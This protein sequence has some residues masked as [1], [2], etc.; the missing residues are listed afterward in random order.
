[1]FIKLIKFYLWMFVVEAAL[2]IVF[3]AIVGLTARAKLGHWPDQREF[4][5]QGRS[6]FEAVGHG[7]HWTDDVGCG[8]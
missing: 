4:K 5:C 7:K 8:Q 6:F 1:M 3:E 2:L